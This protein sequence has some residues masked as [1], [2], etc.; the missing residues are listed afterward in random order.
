MNQDKYIFA[1]LTDFLPRR[2]FD[3]L[4]EKYSGNKKI[5]TFPCWNQML[6]MIFGQLTARDSMRDLIP[7]L[8]AHKNKYYH[9]GF[10]TTVSLTNLGKANRNRDYRICEEFAYTLIA[11]ARNSY[12]KN[13]FEVKVDGN[14]YAFDSFTINLCLNVFWWAEFRKYKGGIKLHTL[15]DVKTSIPTIVLVT[16]AKVHDVNMLD[17]LSYEKGSFYIMDKGYV[18]FTRLHK[19]HTCGAY[20]VTRAKDNM[21]FRRMYSCEVDKTTGIKW[22]QI[23]M[24]KTYKSLKAYSD[25]LRGLNTTMKNWTENLCSSPTTWNSQQ[26]KLLYYIRTVGR[27]NYLS[28]G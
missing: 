23:G 19:L 12:N 4:V 13:D 15:Y 3:R 18:D 5:R 11:E 6:C 7:S 9:L 8:E 14:V 17:E 20:F 21:R 1:Q 16:N 22:D 10:G 27:W 2:V 24:L 26:R 25:K 28:N